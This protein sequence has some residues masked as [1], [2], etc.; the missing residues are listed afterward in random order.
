MQVHIL[1]E[2]DDGD[3]NLYVHH[4]IILP[5]F[6]LCVAWLDCPLKGGEKGKTFILSGWHLYLCSVYYTALM[7]ANRDRKISE[8]VLG[9]VC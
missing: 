2:S 1:E 7:L 8:F 3:P 9:H 5:A 6:P 4:H